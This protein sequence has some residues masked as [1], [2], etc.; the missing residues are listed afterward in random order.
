MGISVSFS[1]RTDKAGVV[2]HSRQTHCSYTTMNHILEKVGLVS[3]TRLDD[4]DYY[5]QF[6]ALELVSA[7]QAFLGKVHF[8]GSL[9]DHDKECRYIEQILTDY[10]ACDFTPTMFSGF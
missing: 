9:Q 8:D 7:F 3:P 5:V 6:D 2:S 4:D 1:D 10:H